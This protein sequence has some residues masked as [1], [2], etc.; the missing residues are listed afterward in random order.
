MGETAREFRR[1]PYVQEWMER[2]D[3]RGFDEADRLQLVLALVETFRVTKI[4]RSLR[5]ADH[6]KISVTAT[7][8]RALR[9]AT[10]ASSANP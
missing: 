5:L 7:S 10:D 4:N 3:R 2:H 9:S 1:V 6:R 8:R